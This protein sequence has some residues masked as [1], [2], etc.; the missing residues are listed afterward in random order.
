MGM[1]AA[2]A[3]GSAHV[4]F[5]LFAVPVRDTPAAG[6]F[7]KWFLVFAFKVDD[8]EIAPFGGHQVIVSA[9]RARVSVPVQRNLLHA[10]HAP[11]TAFGPLD[12]KGGLVRHRAALDGFEGKG[13][14]VDLDVREFAHG[15]A[16]GLDAFCSGIPGG[17]FNHLDD[18]FCE[19]DFMHGT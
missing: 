17:V 10:V 11:G 1:I 16:D 15:D 4:C 6:S 18:A 7:Q 12:H 2:A 13:K 9:G 3:A 8:L 19:R 5:S 14:R